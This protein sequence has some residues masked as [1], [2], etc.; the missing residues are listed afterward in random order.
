MNAKDHAAVSRAVMLS[1]AP[2]CPQDQPQHG[3]IFDASACLIHFAKSEML[4]LMLRTQR[5]SHPNR[6]AFVAVKNRSSV[7]HTCE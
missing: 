3:N 5:R 7:I 4:R 6:H 1:G 2:L